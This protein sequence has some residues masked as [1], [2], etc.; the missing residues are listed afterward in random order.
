MLVKAALLDRPPARS[1]LVHISCAAGDTSAAATVP[2]LFKPRDAGM[3]GAKARPLAAKIELL[4]DLIARRVVYDAADGA[5]AD[6]S[7]ERVLRVLKKQDH[8]LGS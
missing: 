8:D 7:Q 3:L 2:E 5:A 6:W 4:L 1:V